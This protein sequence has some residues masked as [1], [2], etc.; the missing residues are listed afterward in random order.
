MYDV[1]RQQ[2]ASTD[3][4]YSS[5]THMHARFGCSHT[6]SRTYPP[7][8]NQHDHDK[9]TKQQIPARQ[10][11]PRGPGTPTG[12][13][14]RSE[15]TPEAHRCEIAVHDSK[16]LGVRSSEERSRKVHR[17]KLSF[18]V[19]PSLHVKLFQPFACVAPSNGVRPTLQS[20]VFR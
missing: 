17:S 9:E 8:T 13:R 11:R 5:A 2:I 18:S 14:S 20:V 1:L 7:S 19:K 15:E 16:D 10:R 12:K 3:I 6:F 4:T